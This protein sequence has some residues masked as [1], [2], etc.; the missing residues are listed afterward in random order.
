M[1]DDVKKSR[2]RRAIVLAAVALLA[3]GLV[4]VFYG[5]MSDKE[6]R[7]KVAL[8]MAMAREA[9]SA[10]AAY[11]AERKALPPD[12]SALRLPDKESKPYFTAFEQKADL[13]FGILVQGGTLT[14]TFALDQDPVSGKT[15]VFV[16]RIAEGGLEWT[17]NS[18]TVDA[19][20]R[21]AQCRGQ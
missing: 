13:S 20:Y 19:R 12:N 16:P 11:Y 21:P 15:L 18:G 6:G 2:R 17:C 7:I 10:T 9:Q 4:W 3:I 5:G 14:L 8:A 1:T